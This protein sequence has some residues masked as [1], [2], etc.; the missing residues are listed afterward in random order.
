MPKKKKSRKE[1][2][3]EL[4]KD[5]QYC[6]ICGHLLKQTGTVAGLLKACP[7]YHGVMYVT[8]K[9]HGSKI[10]IFLEVHEE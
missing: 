2:L 4:F 6:P 8:G 7:T 10:G 9:R 3:E 5:M 1:I